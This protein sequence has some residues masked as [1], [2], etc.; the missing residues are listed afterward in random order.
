MKQ[1]IIVGNVTSEIE[2]SAKSANINLFLYKDLLVKGKSSR[3][4]LEP[5]TASD[6]CT[7]CYTSGTTGL[8]KGAVFPHSAMI[9]IVSAVDLLI[10]KKLVIDLNE[11][12]IHLSYLP[13]AH[14]FERVVTTILMKVG[15]SIGFYQ[16]DTLKIMDDLGELR[17]T[18]F[19]SV[20]RLFNRIYDKVFAG[21]NMKGAISQYL[22]NMAYESKVKSLKQGHLTHWLWDR[23][24]FA[25]IKARLGGRVRAMITGSAP[26]A[27]EVMDFLRVAFAC[28]V[29]EGYGQTET[30]AASC[31][32]QRGDYSSGHVGGPSP[33]NEC[34][35]IDVPEMS[36]FASGTPSRG[37][38]CFRGPNCF[39][40]YYKEPEKTAET[41][42]ADGWVHS[43]DIGEWDAQGRLKII[44]R[45]KNIF[46][47]AQGEYVAPEKIEN[48][49]SQA[50]YVEQIFV[51]GDSLK[52]FVIAI[53]VPD[54]DNLVKAV[55]GKLLKEVP[56]DQSSSSLT[57]FDY[58]YEHNYQDLVDLVL[59]DLIQ[60]AR[61]NASLKG[62]EIPKAIYLEKTP[63]SV[64]N[65]L[66]TSTFKLKRFEASKYYKASIDQLYQRMKD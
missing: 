59:S 53:V 41:I 15:A 51:Y 31:L 37:E 44:D 61:S 9:A 22:F 43:G 1:I 52:A 2:T 54:K 49:L 29:Y 46:K 32:T 57:T 14:I 5:P 30:C 55:H 56:K 20:P 17:P 66:L 40:E 47:L 42:D 64:P 65:N 21:V 13:L 6:I 45:K 28:E 16:G 63:F 62:F 8:P 7:I 4:E 18:V 26:I 35:L 11:Q 23:L 25:P 27:P 36:Y 19:V 12:E 34:M 24:V 39:T 10:R 38:I 33:C 60:F 3:L 58:L 50:T 48:I